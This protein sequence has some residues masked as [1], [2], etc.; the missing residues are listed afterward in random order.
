MKLDKLFKNRS[1]ELPCKQQRD[2]YFLSESTF[3]HVLESS[4]EVTLCFSQL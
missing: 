2:S 3:I 1:P 4:G